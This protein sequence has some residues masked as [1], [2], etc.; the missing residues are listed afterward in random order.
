[1]EHSG[2]DYYSLQGR[3]PPARD[4][5]KALL[6][7]AV[8]AA[9]SVGA[10]VLVGKAAF[11]P[12]SSNSLPPP[13]PP[14]ELPLSMVWRLALVERHGEEHDFAF[15]NYYFVCAFFSLF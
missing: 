15:G 6:V 12:S 7:V 3:D 11:E 4:R 5:C 10:G 9:A 1:M 13:V 2:S 8:V 14:A